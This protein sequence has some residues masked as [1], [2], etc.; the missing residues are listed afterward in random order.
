M[1]PDVR[2][3]PGASG[4]GQ[5]A[6]ASLFVGALG[7]VFGDIGTS[8]IYTGQTGFNPTDPHPVP[9]TTDNLFGVVSLIFWSLTLIVTIT[10]VLLVMRADNDGGGGILALITLLRRRPPVHGRHRTALALAAVG[11]FGASLFLG[12][13]I[14]TPAI[15]VLSAVEG[16][17]VVEPAL[18]DLVVP[19]TAVIIVA[20]FLAQRRG[21]GAVGRV[22]G[23][24]M[25]AWFAVVAG[26]GLHA[27]RGHPQILKAVSPTYA[28]GFLFGNFKTAFFSLAAV[29]L[30]VT[31]AE[32]LYA[33]MGHFGRRP[34]RLS[35]LLIV[36]PALTLNYLGQG[37]LIL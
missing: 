19:V 31:G 12:D 10:Y 35:W 26:L 30:A 4:V 23:P 22:F 33:D 24:V 9:V 6:S 32:A 16:L 13:S 5:V 11:I 37:A 20:L 25:V 2:A 36:F 34:I 14:I 27:I 15:S 28:L 18:A 29:V 8:P 7:V 21:T 3:E 1:G 17:K